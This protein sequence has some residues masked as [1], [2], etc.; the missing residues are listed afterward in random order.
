MRN[1]DIT[2][3]KFRSEESE[4]LQEAMD[5]KVMRVSLLK[6][7]KGANQ[8]KDHIDYPKYFICIYLFTHHHLGKL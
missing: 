1:E 5:E 6:S 3:E 2:T 7:Q 8:A 4:R